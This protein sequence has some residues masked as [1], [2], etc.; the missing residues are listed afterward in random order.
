MM[1]PFHLGV[2]VGPDSQHAQWKTTIINFHLCLTSQRC[3]RFF[4]KLANWLPQS[5]QKE[6]NKNKQFTINDSTVAKTLFSQFKNYC[7]CY[8][9]L[10]IK[11]IILLF[12]DKGA[13][14]IYVLSL[15]ATCIM[16]F[17]LSKNKQRIIFMTTFFFTSH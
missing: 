12:K 5:L 10:S 6:T 2:L 9:I 13:Y 17:S 15:K 4:Y 7:Y 11:E 8:A 16:Q 14:P 3:L 1:A